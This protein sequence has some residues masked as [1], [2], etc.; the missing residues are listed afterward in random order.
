MSKLHYKIK[1]TVETPIHIGNSLEYTKLD[2][3][4]K[5]NNIY[6]INHNNL[7][8]ILDEKNIY[9]EYLKTVEKEQ[10]LIANNQKDKNSRDLI[11]DFYFRNSNEL[12]KAILY[13]LPIIKNKNRL[14]T[15]GA[16]IK[17]FDNKPY[18][19]GSSIKGA[20]RTALIEEYNL[21]HKVHIRGLSI[22]DTKPIEI[23]N[24]II[25]PR[26]DE[27]FYK[28]KQFPHNLEIYS[29]YL[30][31][32]ATLE[33]TIDIDLLELQKTIPNIKNINDILKAINKRYDRILKI[34]NLTNVAYDY[35]IPKDNLL[36]LGKH[37]GFHS[38]T[39]IDNNPIKV[40]EKTKVILHGKFWK[41]KHCN[42]D[43]ISPRT[44]KIINTSKGEKFVGLVSL[45]VIK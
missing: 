12:E 42:D 21:N 36:F 6:F 28:H 37:T 7:Y 8:K 29:E 35:T 30:K 44:Y 25:L 4:E 3:F 9:D 27:V 13:K 16:F 14:G 18:I 11:N 19:P 1:L 34:L 24:L 26:K 43:L 45:E 2:F 31:E 32:Q 39:I 33:F 41:H 20:I 17:T 10:Y 40:R 38:K 23:N 5:K 22:S 15:I